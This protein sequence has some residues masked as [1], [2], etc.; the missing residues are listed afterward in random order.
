MTF[1]VS[2]LRLGLTFIRRRI[3]IVALLGFICA[4]YAFFV[5]A[6]FQEHW[7]VW[8]T[9][10]DLLAEGF[11]RGQAHV[12][13]IPAPELL[14]AKDPYDPIHMRYWVLDAS[15]Y[16]GK[17]Y[18][19]WGPLPALLQA[20]GKSILGV[21]GIVGDQYVSLFLLC[22]GA[23]AGALLLE[24]ICQR[25][26]PAVPKSLRV[27]SILALAFAG[28]TLHA[29]STASTYHTA[30]VGAQCWLL[31]GLVPAFD[32]VWHAR[33]DRPERLR[34]LLASASWGLALASRLAVAP[35]IAVLA[36]ATAC[37]A[38]WGARNRW[39]AVV[40]HCVWLGIP[41]SLIG[42]GLLAYNRYRFDDW[43][44]FGIHRQVSAFPLTEL[45]TAFWLPNLYSYL[46]RPPE[47]SCEFP[48][49]LQVWRMGL[50]AFPPGFSIPKGY[51]ILEPVIGFVYATPVIWLV[52]FALLLACARAQ[53]G[54]RRR[55]RLWGVVSLGTLSTL[56]G[57]AALGIFWATFR[58]A[59]D[60][61]HGIALLGAVGGFALRSS[62]LGMLLPRTTSVLVGS[63]FSITVALGLLIGYQGYNGQFL[64]HNPELHAKLVGALSVCGDQKPKP[65]RYVP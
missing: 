63:I 54:S 40:V 21:S 42:F 34:L 11:R 3:G 10:H 64:R 9:F 24:R 15:Y 7:P 13:L 56:S 50:S 65:I 52:P 12:P 5:S 48:F 62:R 16:R 58:Y 59:G 23:W 8:G 32:V 45:S 31:V 44:D 55:T 49:F 28:P 22:V 36:L 39:R 30:I 38:G 47:L 41:L 33:S 14:A 20:I 27:L 46:L 53:A 60:V 4:V 57:F 2:G 35:A 18:I 61:M 25:L 37:A 51:L 17:Y 29:A 43:L 1:R 19:Y 6:G 26:F